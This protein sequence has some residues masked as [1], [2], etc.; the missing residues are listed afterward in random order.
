MRGSLLGSVVS[1]A[2]ETL[3]RAG[4]QC[5]AVRT[6]DDPADVWAAALDESGLSGEALA[7]QRFTER[8]GVDVVA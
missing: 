8:E 1:I 5:I 2:I 3:V 7:R 6:T 4:W